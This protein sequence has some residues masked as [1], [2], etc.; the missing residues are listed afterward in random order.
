MVKQH[1][2]TFNQKISFVL[3][4]ILLQLSDISLFAQADGSLGNEQVDVVKE[5][6]PLIQDANKIVFPPEPVEAKPEPISLQYSVP[7]RLMPLVYPQSNLKPLAIAKEKQAQYFNSY[8]RLG[9]GSQ[10][11]PLGEVFFA[12][13]KPEKSLFGAHAKYRSSHGQKI[14]SQDYTQTDASVFAN[15]YIKQSLLKAKVGYNSDVVHY[16]AYDDFS[17]NYT[18]PL[19]ELKQKDLKQTFSQVDVAV[20]LLN[21][22]RRKSAFDYN[23]KF[24]YNYFWDK[25]KLNEQFINADITLKKSIKDKHHISL[26]LMEDYSIFKD[27]AGNTLNRNIFSTKAKY[28]FISGDWNIFGAV[29][30]VWQAGIFHLFPDIGL[31]RGI[32]DEYIVLYNGWK[33]ELRKNSYASLTQQNPWLEQL[34]VNDIRN[35]WLEERFMGLKG[36]IKKFNY[37]VRFAQNLYRH[38]PVFVNQF[39]NAPTVTDADVTYLRPDFAVA[40][41]RRT[42]ILNLHTELGYR[43][44]SDLQFNFVFDFNNFEPDRISKIY[45]QPRFSARF[46]TRYT[47]AEKVLLQLDII[48]LDGVYYINHPRPNEFRGTIDEK[49]KGTLDV[50]LGATYIFSNRFSFFAQLNNLASVKYQRYY[51]YP[52]FGF[53]AMA[54]ITL[55]F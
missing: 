27:V 22:K 9:F 15:T 19:I 49:L 12:E 29:N 48:G 39:S 5:F 11:S 30:P 36:T 42:N 23:G 17:K 50:S 3:I 53:N 34:T 32:Y 8:A 55:H 18:L 38:M 47:I 40:Y 35:G 6:N 14:K 52:S 21:A 7:D 37:N 10:W 28:H 44:N 25:F 33:M 1:K 54:G 26:Q 20:D 13:G 24:N 51:L 16:F 45:H 43:V 4:F 46:N 2:I 31:Q 41:D